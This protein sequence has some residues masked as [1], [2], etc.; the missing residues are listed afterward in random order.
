MVAARGRPTGRF[1]PSF[2]LFPWSRRKR[3]DLPRPF[4]ASGLGPAV[5]RPTVAGIGRQSPPTRNHR[6]YGCPV[7]ERDTESAAAWTVFSRR[8]LRR[9]YD[10]VRS[11][12]AT[13][14]AWRARCPACPVRH[15]EL[16]KN[17]QDAL[18]QGHLY[19]SALGVS[20]G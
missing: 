12:S 11:G 1:A 14:S 17:S 6:R 15:D 2:I 9:R 16:V 20:R 4:A 3:S 13:P 10:R 18:E 19:F 8:L 7:R 5:L